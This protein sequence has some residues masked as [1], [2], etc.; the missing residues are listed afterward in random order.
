MMNFRSY[1]FTRLFQLILFTIIPLGCLPSVKGEVFNPNRISKHQLHNYYTQLNIHSQESFEADITEDG[2]PEI[3][4]AIACGDECCEYFCFENNVD[5]TYSYVGSLRLKIG[6]FEISNISHNGFKDIIMTRR[7]NT[8]KI[9]R[10]HYEVRNEE[11]VIVENN[12]MKTKDV[13]KE[14]TSFLTRLNW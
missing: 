10:T 4:V 2:Y 1:I 12:Q 7:C 5:G 11:Y 6:N 13:A 14:D 9:V 3:F 8:G